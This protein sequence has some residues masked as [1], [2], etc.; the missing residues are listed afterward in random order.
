M[1]KGE[2]ECVNGQTREQS[3]KISCSLAAR[4]HLPDML[5][6]RSDVTS[7]SMTPRLS[8]LVNF[9]EGK[10]LPLARLIPSQ[11]TWVLVYS[12]RSSVAINLV[13]TKTLRHRGYPPAR[14]VLECLGTYLPK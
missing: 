4:I 12:F 5:L 14:Y 13:H 7:S 2:K 1:M 8:I 10:Y 3:N 11:H 6:T 9:I